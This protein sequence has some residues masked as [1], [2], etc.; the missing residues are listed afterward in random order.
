MRLQT[1]CLGRQWN[2]PLLHVTGPKLLHRWCRNSLLCNAA[3]SLKSCAPPTHKNQFL[4]ISFDFCLE[5]CEMPFFSVGVTLT[6]LMNLI[7]DRMFPIIPTR[8]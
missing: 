1:V 7:L 5:F 6:H 8:S 2:A 3:H 4:V